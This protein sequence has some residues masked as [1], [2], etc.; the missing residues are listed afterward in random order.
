MKHRLNLAVVGALLAACLVSI[1]SAGPIA[2]YPTATSPLTGA[3]AVVGTQA[4]KTVQVTAA[5]LAAYAL[6]WTPN[7][8]TAASANST[9]LY[10]CSQSG[11]T[12]KCTASQI[13]A[14]GI[15]YVPVNKAG[16]TIT[17]VVHAPTAAITDASTQLATDAFVTVATAHPIN[18]LQYG[19]CT[20]CSAA[21]NT[22]AINAALTVACSTSPGTIYVPGTFTVTAGAIHQTCGDVGW[23][24]D[25]SEADGLIVTSSTGDVLN[26]SGSCPSTQIGH[27][28]VRHLSLGRTVN[29]G[30]GS[31]SAALRITCTVWA[32]IEDVFAYNSVTQFFSTDNAAIYIRRT[33]AFRTANYQGAGDLYYG[34]HFTTANYGQGNV[35][36]VDHAY[37]SPFVSDGVSYDGPSTGF[38]FNGADMRNFQCTQCHS[39]NAD[40]G[41]EIDGSA[42]TGDT[43]FA[44]I[45]FNGAHSDGY[46]HYGFYLH[47]FNN[48]GQIV[49]DGGTWI[50]PGVGDQNPTYGIY[51]SNFANIIV[52]GTINYGGQTNP[53]SYGLYATHGYNL[54]VTS[55]NFKDFTYPIYLD[56]AGGNVDFYNI[57]NN[58]LISET[59]L[60]T[61]N[62]ITLT[63]SSNGAVAGNGLTGLESL[64]A[65]KGIVGDGTLLGDTYIGFNQLNPSAFTGALISGVPSALGNVVEN[66]S[67]YNPVGVTTGTVDTSPAT[68]CSGPTPTSFYWTQSA[69]NT[70]TV[71]KAGNIIGTMSSATTVIRDD[72]GANE[73]DVVTWATTA[74]TY[75][76]SVH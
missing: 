42:T 19:A 25:R 27:V 4:T 26:I 59:G 39:D 44:D 13:A 20:T 29:P 45:E 38:L 31:N 48:S 1:C 76:K 60:T 9:D 64:V 75:T 30:I 65:T 15:G 58:Q 69:T 50:T 47:D 10:A 12:R 7:L 49:I 18:I 62:G 34:Y 23:E 22:T 57:S 40:I 66:N 68:M 35:I 37:S 14:S 21:V 52:N 73:C 70:A 6:G 41:Y 5:Q 33:H 54:T 3:E 43:N 8:S 36:M 2:T 71:A 17:G 51:A 16:D 63:G 46:G 72:L 67:N 32:D 56:N 53:T 24:G 61:I 11:I 55:N 28:F 74:P